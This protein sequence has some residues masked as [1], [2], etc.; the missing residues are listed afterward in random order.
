MGH[1][2]DKWHDGGA[3]TERQLPRHAER[4]L[5]AYQVAGESA[6]QQASHTSGRA[7]HP[8]ESPDCFDV[9]AASVV[10]ILW[11]PEQ[12]EK[13]CCVAQ[14]FR[15]HQPPGL[16]D[17]KQAD[18]RQ[19]GRRARSA[20]LN[21]A[22]GGTTGTCRWRRIR[23]SP[24]RNPEQTQRARENEDPAPVRVSENSRDQR[25]GRDCSD[26][27]AGIDDA[28][29]GGALFCRKPFRNRAGRGR[30]PAAFAHTQQESACGQHRKTGG[31]S[32]A[33]TGQR[34]EQHDHRK[35]AMRS[36]KVHQFAAA[37][38]HQR[39][40]EQERRLERRKLSVGQRDVFADRLDRDWQSLPIKVADCDRSTD[41]DGD[42][43][44]QNG[45]PPRTNVPLRMF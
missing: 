36:Q 27:G 6:A 13:P 15:G 45:F 9:K 38:I 2:N 24:P 31:Q 23:Q 29:R 32:V 7:G 18:P 42:A 19:T 22:G 44:P 20:T 21:R 10:E 43:P 40:G 34:P 33:G 5:A 37:R 30:K 35:P 26:C 17:A 3:Q 14:K 4:E 8:G 12:V 39:I 1:Q 41:Q 25:R 16:T 28:H 11:E